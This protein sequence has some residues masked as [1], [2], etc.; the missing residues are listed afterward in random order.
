MSGATTATERN[1]ITELFDPPTEQRELVRHY[2][3]VRS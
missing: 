1:Q 3:L 2:T